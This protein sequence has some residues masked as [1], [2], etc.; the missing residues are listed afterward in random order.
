MISMTGANLDVVILA[1]MGESWRAFSTWYSITKNLPDAHVSV[2]CFRSTQVDIQ[3]YHWAKRLS[4]PF[5]YLNPSC[6]EPIGD[7]LTILDRSF[8]HNSGFLL[9]DYSTIVIRPLDE[10]WLELL[11]D[12]EPGLLIDDHIL[13]ARQINEGLL[14]KM[15]TQFLFTGFFEG[16]PVEC[17]SLCPE[18]KESEDPASI[19]T[20][21]KGCGRWIDTLKVCPFSHTEAILCDDMTINE[22]RIVELWRKMVPLYDVAN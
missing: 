5:C 6:N 17:G 3:G 8:R 13:V 4:V 12:P 10:T 7:R 15:R 19:V 22:R 18:A 11:N 9:L 1:R 2:I 20:T 16:L 21:T 14:E